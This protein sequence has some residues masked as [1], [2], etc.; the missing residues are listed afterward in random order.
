[1]SNTVDK[2]LF[3]EDMFSNSYI[4]SQGAYFIKSSGGAP[5]FCGIRG[6]RGSFKNT[7]NLT[8]VMMIILK[9]SRVEKLDV[10]LNDRNV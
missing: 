8:T 10:C 1:M 7:N 5:H 2:S 4:I 6:W 9:I 3:L